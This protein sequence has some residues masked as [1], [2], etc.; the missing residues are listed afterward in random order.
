MYDLVERVK[1]ALVNPNDSLWFPDLTA[2]LAE[3]GWKKLYCTAG[4]SHHDYTTGRVMLQDVE[5]PCKII[6][7]QLVHLNK[8]SS[9]WAP[10]VEILG[11]ELTS[12]Y[13]QS[14]ISFYT[15]EEINDTNILKTLGD[16]ISILKRLPTL[17]ATIAALVKSI[18]I[19]KLE[20]D[21]YDVSFS[22]PHIPFSIFISV[23]HRHSLTV[24]LRITEA[25]VHEAMHL[26]LTHIERVT[27]LVAQTSDNYFS[28]WR[29]EYRT[30]QGV[31]HALY[32]FKVI[33]QLFKKL[34]VDSLL[35]EE[36]E[37]ILNRCAEIYTQIQE[38]QGFKDCSDLTE[39]GR[40]FA[41]RLLS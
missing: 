16:G 19:I 28:P 18:H 10:Q 3:A 31:L 35:D 4:V 13:E 40:C 21:D 24:P 41:R 27:T 1:A 12:H 26:Q 32:V 30:A 8:K 2:E 37:Y 17:Y 9:E 33:D 23:P 5:A 14:G 15:A 11:G 36:G 6:A 38:I 22:D 29:G 7:Y 25:I 34:L 39:V 20:N